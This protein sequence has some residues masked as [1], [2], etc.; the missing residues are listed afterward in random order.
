MKGTGQ[1]ASGPESW[2]PSWD[3][4]RKKKENLL[5]I[6]PLLEIFSVSQDIFHVIRLGYCM[7]LNRC[8]YLIETFDLIF[9][10]S[11]LFHVYS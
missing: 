3:P 2:G 4:P 1:W 6:K 7:F 5:V 11:P 8:M 9:N 10:F